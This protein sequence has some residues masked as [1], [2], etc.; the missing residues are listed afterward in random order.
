[1]SL[2]DADGS[3]LPDHQL[4]VVETLAHVDHTIER[5]LRLTHDYT[6]RGTITFAEVSNGD[7]VDVMVREIAPLPQAIPRLVADALA[8]LR[9]ALEH[10]VV[11]LPGIRCHLPGRRRAP[12]HATFTRLLAALDGDALD[13]AIGATAHLQARDLDHGLDSATAAS[14]SSLA[15]SPAWPWT[16]WPNLIQPWPPGGASQL[17]A[18]P[19]TAPAQNSASPPET[20]PRPGG[21]PRRHN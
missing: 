8:Q 18:N 1:M 11:E 7:R 3:W 20:P 4:H 12:S 16:T 6:E 10:T 14:T 9:A 5:L 19:S 13:A 2:H 15:S 17:S 21:A